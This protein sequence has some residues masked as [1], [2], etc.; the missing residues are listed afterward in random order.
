MPAVYGEIAAPASLADV[1]ECFWYSRES[2]STRVHRVAPDGCADILFTRGTG[3]CSLQAIGA[4]TRFEDFRIP[5]PQLL[6]GAR[7]R[8][9]RWA[10]HLG[11]PGDCITDARPPL[12]ALW[13]ARAR[14]LLDRLGDASSPEE[15]AAV[16]AG[17]L[18]AS[19]SRTPVQKA[20]AFMEAR[21]G[22]VSVD[23]LARLAGVS[24]RQ[25]RRLC[26]QET[27]LSPKFLA[28]VLRFRRALSQVRA[29][30]GEH[31]GLA[32]ECGYTDQSHLIAEFREF[33]GQTPAAFLN[34]GE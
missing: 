5:G 19:D 11:V 28:R 32:A 26:L 6:V 34:S 29:Q 17:S 14:S 33:Y 25:F 9:G 30:A 2:D 15:C 8:P 10:A 16:L 23:E 18:Q 12:D 20:I 24:A 22:R 4:M 3:D 27:G 7:F 31:A 13:G 21:A 1:V